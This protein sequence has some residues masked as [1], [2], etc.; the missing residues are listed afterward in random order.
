MTAAIKTSLSRLDQA[1]GQLESAVVSTEKKAKAPQTDLFG[2]AA[3]S[4]KASVAND[5]DPKVLANR[6]DNAISKVEQI[7]REEGRA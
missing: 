2:V 5:V 4:Q 6:L 1:V 3:G 7:L